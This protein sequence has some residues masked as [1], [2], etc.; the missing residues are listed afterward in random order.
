VGVPA[1][2]SGKAAGATRSIAGDGAGH[3]GWGYRRIHGE[4]MAERELAG[5]EATRVAER[6]L[7]A[8]VQAGG[9]ALVGLLRVRVGEQRPATTALAGR[10]TRA[11]RPRRSTRRCRSRPRRGGGSYS[12]RISC[13]T[14]EHPS[15]LQL[16][17]SP[18]LVPA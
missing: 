5:P 8:V 3:P 9:H 4:L 14:T 18:P 12:A 7:V 17:G 6:D 2:H 13:G 16:G 1:S 10:C 11:S 15:G